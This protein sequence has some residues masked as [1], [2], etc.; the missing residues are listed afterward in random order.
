MSML[1]RVEE[2]RYAGPIDEYGDPIPGLR[3]PMGISIKEIPVVKRTPKGWR[4][5]NGRIVLESSA[6]KYANP[7]IDGA[8]K[9]FEA[10]KNRQAQIYM[11]RAADA[12][13]ARNGAA[14]LKDA[15]LQ[16]LAKSQLHYA[17]VTTDPWMDRE[18]IV[19]TKHR[20]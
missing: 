9:D 2:T 7:T 3:G 14:R 11:T 1:F 12:I 5:A 15:L 18:N 8:F 16:K 10:R 19:S 20:K 4:L 6:K 13:E 17:S